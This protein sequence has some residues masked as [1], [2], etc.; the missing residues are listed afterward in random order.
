MAVRLCAIFL[1]ARDPI[2]SRTNGQLNIMPNRWFETERTAAAA[3]NLMA[4]VVA[5][6]QAT[7]QSQRAHYS[8]RRLQRLNLKTTLFLIGVLA[9]IAAVCFLPEFLSG[10]W[11][12]QNDNLHRVVKWLL[13]IVPVGFGCRAKQRMKRA[14]Q[15]AQAHQSCIQQ[16]VTDHPSLR[17]TWHSPVLGE[18]AKSIPYLPTSCPTKVHCNLFGEYRKQAIAMLE[19]EYQEAAKL[20]LAKAMQQLQANLC[21]DTDK[22]QFS[23]RRVAEAII[24]FRPLAQL[25]D[26]FIAGTDEPL[27]AYQPTWV[28]SVQATGQAMP[29]T[30]PL[31][32]RWNAFSS[33]P[34]TASQLFTSEL[35][36]LFLIR[37]TA[38]V[39]IIGGFVV[40]IPR[41]WS[42]ATPMNTAVQPFEIQLDLDFA[43]AIYEQLERAA[44][45][46]RGVERSLPAFTTSG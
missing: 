41:T 17:N 28:K 23:R 36:E 22:E 24:F 11:L 44:R 9:F 45:P 4:E 1:G 39:Q 29:L 3:R 8:E 34:E 33:C 10:E 20:E 35:T 15:R 18:S 43:C 32:S 37:P 26:L 2:L 27:A 21:E 16:I 31:G 14:G 42:A 7:S 5:S 13:V 12:S 25:P 40:V 38:M 30:T 46:L 6:C 19:V